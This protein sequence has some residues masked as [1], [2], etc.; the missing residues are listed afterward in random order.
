MLPPAAQYGTG[1][2]EA[3]L[4]KNSTM[5]I[6]IWKTLIFICLANLFVA[7]RV[8]KKNI[9]YLN[10]KRDSTANVIWQSY[11]AKIQP[12]DRLT[13]SVSALNPASAQVYSLGTNGSAG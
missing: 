2:S 7:C 8:Q 3:S 13:V 6:Y 11:E 10:D 12:G 5:R 9:N 4:F 1:N